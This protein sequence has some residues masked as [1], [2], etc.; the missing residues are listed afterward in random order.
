MF[1]SLYV[2]IFRE[3]VISSTSIISKLKKYKMK[4]NLTL[5]YLFHFGCSHVV[6]KVLGNTSVNKL[7][8]S[9]RTRFNILADKWLS[10]RFFWE[11]TPFH[12]VII[13]RCFEITSSRSKRSSRIRLDISTWNVPSHAKNCVSGQLRRH[14]NFC[15]K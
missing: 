2:F 7:Q 1:Y 11:M 13:S 8:I 5:F 10:I 3:T 9:A 4:Y 12:L 6:K 15:Q 14:F